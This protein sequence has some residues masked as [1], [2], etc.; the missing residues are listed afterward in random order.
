MSDTSLK[1]KWSKKENDLM[2]NYPRR[3]D[4]AFMNYILGNMLVWG[5]IDGKDKGWQNF[6][7][8]NLKEECEKRGYDITTLKI[9]IKLKNENSDTR[10]HCRD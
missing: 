10:S 6:N 8:F 4:G 9:E 1:V 5:G 7:T 2:I 3:C